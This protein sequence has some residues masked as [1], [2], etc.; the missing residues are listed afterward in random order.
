VK[1]YTRE[2]TVKDSIPKERAVAFLTELVSRSLTLDDVESYLKVKNM[3]DA[4]GLTIGDILEFLES[5]KKAGI[6]PP[7]LA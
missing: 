2:V 4:R 6:M 7:R 5:V 1:L 3:L